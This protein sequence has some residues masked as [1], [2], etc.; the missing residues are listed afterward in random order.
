MDQHLDLLARLHRLLGAF[1]VLAGLSLVVLAAGAGLTLVDL[2]W[3]RPA[4]LAG[5]MLL[6]AVGVTLSGGGLTLAWTGH[7]LGRRRVIGRA[8]ALVMAA[9]VLAAVPFG[10]ALGLYTYWVL[11]NDEA[12]LAFGRPPRATDAPLG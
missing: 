12:R 6:V 8:L 2:P 4:G 10:T 1:A 7:A 9:P 5:A 11:L 3:R